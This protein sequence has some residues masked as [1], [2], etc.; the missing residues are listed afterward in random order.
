MN[1]GDHEAEPRGSLE[2]L[3]P[4]PGKPQIN[5]LS[6]KFVA[7]VII[8]IAYSYVSREPCHTSP[9]RYQQ[10]TCLSCSS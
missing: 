2:A 1:V 9:I 7:D 5:R 6:G 8:S 4:H 10:L 3:E